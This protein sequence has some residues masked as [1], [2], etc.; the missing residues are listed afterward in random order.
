MQNV[1]F[2]YRIFSLLLQKTWSTDVYDFQYFNQYF[3]LNLR[4]NMKKRV[5]LNALSRA[6]WRFRQFNNTELK[7][8]TDSFLPNSDG[9]NQLLCLCQ[10]L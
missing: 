2:L 7:N 3:S 4:Q 6:V 5:I 1:S 9:S 10:W 8:Q